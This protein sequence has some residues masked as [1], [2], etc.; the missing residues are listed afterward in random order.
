MADISTTEPQSVYAGDTVQWTRTLPDYPASAGWVLTYTLLNAAG[1]L[2]MVGTASGDDHAVSV[3]AATTATW[4][5]G[6]YAWRAQVALAGQVFTVGEGRMTVLPSFAA[7]TLE[8]RSFAERALAAVEAYLADAGNLAAASY[9]IA[10]RQLSRYSLPD[11]MAT[12]DRLKAEV[13]REQAAARLAAG[14]PDRRRVFVRF[15]R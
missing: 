8:T 9:Q 11:L 1:K 6:D 14:L 4:A 5:A 13:A 12:R 3:A 2:T 7:P 10:G 15:G